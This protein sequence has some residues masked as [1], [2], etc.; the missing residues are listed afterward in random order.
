MK[1]KPDWDD[2]QERLTALWQGRARGR[3]CLAVTAPS[4]RGLQPPP[5]PPD[6][7]ARWLDPDT[8]LGLARTQLEN[9]WWGGESIPSF[10]LM[11]G[12]VVSLGGTP[13]FD[14]RTIWF[15]PQPV[16]FTHASPFRHDPA[17]PW[18]VKHRRLY[19]RALAAA[20]WDDFLVGNPCILPANDLLSMHMG[21][22]TFLLALVDQPEWMRKAIRTGA[23]DLVRAR[24]DLR[25]MA[26][27]RHRFPFGIAG[28][29]PFWAPESFAST[30]SDVSCLL[31]PDMFEE[32][33]VP[34]LDELAAAYGAL[35]YHLDGGNARQHLPR[36]LSLPAL[37]V[38]QYTPMP[39]EPPNG[40]EHLALYRQIQAAGRI[41]HIAVPKTSVEP[42]IRALDP[43]LLMLQTSCASIEEGQDL[44]RAAERWTAARSG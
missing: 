34:E 22:D 40:P 11:G 3:P 38:I 12:W 43:G 5:L 26:E 18:V 14:S 7:E 8:V 37:R 28:W 25:D 24:R 39:S 27:G 15:D 23:R 31:S 17:D 13:H 6:P 41:V 2:A 29:M 9:T 30:Q 21:T 44:L 42:L 20:G 19:E 33:V 36:L 35:W 4:G 10:L 1:Y 32:F 16:D